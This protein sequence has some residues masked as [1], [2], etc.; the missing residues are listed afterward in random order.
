MFVL[1]ST[2]QAKLIGGQPQPAI[3]AAVKLLTDHAEKNPNKAIT[4]LKTLVLASP[5]PRSL[6][7]PLIT[8]LFLHSFLYLPHPFPH[9]CHPFPLT[10]FFFPLP[11]FF[12]SYSAQA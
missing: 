2:V 11:F 7:D 8:R 3:E 6:L 1:N 12:V 10:C 4:A 5:P 9:L